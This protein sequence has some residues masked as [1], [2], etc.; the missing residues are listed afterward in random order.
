[1]EVKR[2]AKL[3]MEA[4][5]DPVNH[6]SH[7]RHT[8]SYTLRN[9]ATLRYPCPTPDILVTTRYYMYDPNTN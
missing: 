4:D 5:E 7:Y 3:N 8:R 2:C 1:V 6:Y 9:K